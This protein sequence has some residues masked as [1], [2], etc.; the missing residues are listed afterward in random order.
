MSY[1]DFIKELKNADPGITIT[2][3]VLRII[4]GIGFVIGIWNYMVPTS[5][6][7]EGLPSIMSED[8]YREF[9][10]SII[11]IAVLLTYSAQAIK[12]NYTIG[13]RIAQASVILFC[14]MLILLGASF[15]GFLDGFGDSN[16]IK[17]VSFIFLLIVS[18]QFLIPAY[19]GLSYLQK[20]FL[21]MNSDLE[22]GTSQQQSINIRSDHKE[23]E[24]SDYKDSLF[25]FG[26]NITFMIT[27]LPFMVAI[28]LASEF[29]DEA[30]T[31]LIFMTCFLILFF[32][33]I[34]YNSQDSPFETK[35]ELI[36]SHVLG[37]SVF[38]FSG[39]WPFFRLL[40]YKDGIEV[41][42]MYHRFFLPYYKS[43]IKEDRKMMRTDI[44]IKSDLLDVPSKIRLYTGKSKKIMKEIDKLRSVINK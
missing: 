28:L 25:P 31:P 21:K 20:L 44:L 22:F 37:G 29:L 11:I 7:F 8:I 34:I 15:I 23:N 19:F 42:T 18:L 43:E 4:A 3:K 39:T 12:N 13:I 2:V 32:G 30:Y 33:P 41:R 16:P 38:L 27:F 26:V 14:C 24:I 36:S 6:F 17:Y 35:R 5:K 40:I 1:I 9:S 10:F